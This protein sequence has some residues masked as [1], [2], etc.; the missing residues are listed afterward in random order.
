MAMDQAKKENNLCSSRWNYFIYIG[1]NPNTTTI[2]LWKSIRR[3][4]WILWGMFV[5]K[6]KP[7]RYEIIGSMVAAAG[8][9]IIFYAPR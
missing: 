1:G 5:D 6:K 7:D 2:K 9:A 4:W 3:L 8:A